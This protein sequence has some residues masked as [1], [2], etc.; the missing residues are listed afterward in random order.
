[1]E[2]LA[3]RPWFGNSETRS[4][5]AQDSA[6]RNL[7][8]VRNS[9]P[10]VE[11]SL[12]ARHIDSFRNGTA[13]S[14]ATGSWQ[15]SVTD[16]CVVYYIAFAGTI[17]AWAC[18]QTGCIQ[19]RFLVSGHGFSLF[20]L[21]QEE[22]SQIAISATT[23]IAM[24]VLGKCFAWGLSSGLQG[25]MG[26]SPSCIEIHAET[27]QWV[28]VSGSAVAI[29]GID[30]HSVTHIT[31][32]ETTSHQ[33]H[34]FVMHCNTDTTREIRPRQM[35]ILPG[36]KSVVFFKRF[37]GES[38]YVWF[39]RTNLKGQIES[40]GRMEHPDIEDYSRHS[41]HLFPVYT[42]NCVTIW[43]YVRRKG[44]LD[45]HQTKVNSWEIMR[46]VYDTKTDQLE[47]RRHTVQHSIQTKLRATDFFWWKDVAYFG[48]YENELGKLEIL[49]LNTSV[50]KNAHMCTST[51][52]P[53]DEETFGNW[54]NGD[55]W[56]MGN[57]TFLLYVRYVHLIVFINTSGYCTSSS[58]LTEY[59]L[60][61]SWSQI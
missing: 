53:E 16:K 49:D 47:V 61:T 20:T 12:Q 6:Q 52:V 5:I 33:T 39:Q 24:T 60:R 13:F 18:P 57:E 2:T 32:W 28:S 51:L 48:N 54:H 14:M 4:R 3:L 26:Q 17:L 43:S 8:F 56:L 25:L 58:K 9:P 46:V 27:H 36:A 37:L 35:I 45:I 15:T 29:L 30:E 34:R 42:D 22:I 40:S 21:A 1:M 7:G 38:R 11:T 31:T 19:L 50:C 23:V 41:E 55:S 10:D 59:L 44:V